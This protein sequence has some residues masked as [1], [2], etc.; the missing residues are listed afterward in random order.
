MIKVLVHFDIMR[1]NIALLRKKIGSNVRVCAVI[2]NNANRLGD[3]KVFEA[4][5]DYVDYVSCEHISEAF[6]M[7]SICNKKPIL[8]FGSCPNIKTCLEQNIEISINN[9][10]EADEL[11][12]VCKE[13]DLKANVHIKID[14]GFYRFGIQSESELEAILHGFSNSNKNISVVGAYT[15]PYSENRQDLDKIKQKFELFIRRIKQVYPNVIVHAVTSGTNDMA[16][17]AP[18][19][20]YDMVRVGRVLYGATLGYKTAISISS[21][22]MDLQRV[23]KG[24]TIG[25]G[26]G[27]IANND[28]V[29][30]TVVGGYGDVVPF[31]FGKVVSVLVDSKPCKI[32]GDINT[33]SFMIDVSHIKDALYKEVT[34]L[35][36]DTEQAWMNLAKQSGMPTTL[37]IA[38]LN[39]HRAEI[40]YI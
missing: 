25:Y 24:Q 15:H 28:M 40:I 26:G 9:V 39:F 22:I 1:Q 31:Q 32:M 38:T 18:E 33:G 12:K 4:L 11:I 34:I 8:L 14:T 30:G 13:H 29:L 23:E 3:I 19:L 36:P 35:S 16:K 10:F 5:K 17:T 27:E 6:R 7:R 2:K 20:H 21:K 37:L